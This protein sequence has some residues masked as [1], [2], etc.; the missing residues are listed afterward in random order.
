MNVNFHSILHLIAPETEVHNCR[1]C[2]DLIVNIAQNSTAKMIDAR[3]VSNVI[4]DQLRADV[5]ENSTTLEF[6]GNLLKNSITYDIKGEILELEA[7][8]SIIHCH[9]CNIKLVSQFVNCEIHL[10][11][12][13][14]AERINTITS[15]SV[16]L[17]G[18]NSLADTI[19]NIT[20]SYIVQNHIAGQEKYAL[21]K[22]I[23]F[24]IHS[25]I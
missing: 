13:K 19:G 10:T 11:S 15:T 8:N 7:I 12:V 4:C 20:D 5:V 24:I 9:S 14:I 18:N 1:D 16:H 22:N 3:M 21:S 23:D 2:G 6:S 17:Y 25:K